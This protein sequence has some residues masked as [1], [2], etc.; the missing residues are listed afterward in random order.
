M[1]RQFSWKSCEPESIYET[2]PIN[3]AS[4]SLE[5]IYQPIIESDLGIPDAIGQAIRQAIYP[6]VA[7]K[8]VHEAVGLAAIANTF[9]LIFSKIRLNPV[10]CLRLVRCFAFSHP[11]EFDIPASVSVHG[12]GSRLRSSN[13]T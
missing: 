7:R 11:V 4:F 8:S 3:Q 1:Q 6:A 5:P 9:G 13:H 12:F 2:V 10:R